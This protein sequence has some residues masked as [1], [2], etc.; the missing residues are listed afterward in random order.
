MVFFSYKI[1]SSFKPTPLPKDY[2]S[3]SLDLSQVIRATKQKSN[4]ISH[5]SPLVIFKQG[6]YSLSKLNS[7]FS[8]EFCI[9]NVIS[10]SLNH[11][12]AL[13][14]TCS[15]LSYW[16]LKCASQMWT[17]E[18]QIR[19]E[20]AMQSWTSYHSLHSSR[21]CT[22]KNIGQGNNSFVGHQLFSWV[23]L[24]CHA[25]DP[26]PFPP[27][28]PCTPAQ[29]LNTTNITEDLLCVS[30]SPASLENQT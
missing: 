28:P 21:H 27:F 26:D 24:L 22:S 9:C 15:S 7:Q 13:R 20:S 25:H 10:S 17:A 12:V 23:W 3:Y 11:P 30:H 5:N 29:L 8:Q 1:L 4:P 19:S 6:S 2:S 16:A 14:W 18:L